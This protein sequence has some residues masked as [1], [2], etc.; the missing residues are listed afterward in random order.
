MMLESD[1]LLSISDI[2]TFYTK[3]KK[4][5]IKRASEADISSWISQIESQDTT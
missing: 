4:A 5:P 2:L 1:G 3:A